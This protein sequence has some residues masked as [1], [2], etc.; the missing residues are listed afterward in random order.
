[1][2]LTEHCHYNL[3]IMSGEV[4]VVILGIGEGMSNSQGIILYHRQGEHY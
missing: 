4:A 1:M 2:I 3:P